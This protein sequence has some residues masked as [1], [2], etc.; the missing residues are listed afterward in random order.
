MDF[1]PE[2]PMF[3]WLA[4]DGDVA[5]KTWDGFNDKMVRLCR[6]VSFLDEKIDF[7]QLLNQ[8]FFVINFVNL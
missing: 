3:P 4:R 7:F 1:C 6:K 2:F 8:Q 5:Q